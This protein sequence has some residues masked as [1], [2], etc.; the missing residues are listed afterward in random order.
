[1]NVPSAWG[2]ENLGALCWPTMWSVVSWRGPGMSTR[3]GSTG[4]GGAA[5]DSTPTNR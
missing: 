1:M 3:N 4:A 2:R 5:V